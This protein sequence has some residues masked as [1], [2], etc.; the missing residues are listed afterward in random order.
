MRTLSCLAQNFMKI[1]FGNIHFIILVLSGIAYQRKYFISCQLDII[2]SWMLQRNAQT[3]HI[4]FAMPKRFRGKTEPQIWKFLILLIASSTWIGSRAI[5]CV[6]TTS[7]G[8]ISA[9]APRNGGIFKETPKGK[10]SLVV[11]PLSPSTESPS[12]YFVT[13]ATGI[14]WDCST[15]AH[16]SAFAL[17]AQERSKNFSRAFIYNYVVHFYLFHVKFTGILFSEPYQLLH[18][19]R[20]SNSRWFSWQH[21]PTRSWCNTVDRA[22]VRTPSFNCTAHSSLAITDGSLQEP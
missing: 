18:N 14:P 6:F 9:A 11:K 5:S 12:F 15:H 21:E 17:R 10:M 13:T 2:G 4:W 16:V 1:Q 19:D 22:L 7:S 3:D 20:R 8:G